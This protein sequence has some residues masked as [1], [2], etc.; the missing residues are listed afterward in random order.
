[1]HMGV[2]KGVRQ[3]GD[4]DAD[5]EQCGEGGEPPLIVVELALTLVLLAGA[6]FM[7]RSFLN[8]YRLDL[9]ID[10]ARLLTMRVY[11]PLTKYPDAAPRAALYQQFEDR[12]RNIPGVTAAA[13]AT[14]PPMGGGFPLLG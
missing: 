13:L 3:H 6:T 9:G 11:L 1:M 2:A 12:L 4:H 14:N 5:Q 8:M 10:T 7:M